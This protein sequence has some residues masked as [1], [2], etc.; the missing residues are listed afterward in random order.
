MSIL[1]DEEVI[2]NCITQIEE[3]HKE[4]GDN[5][6]PYQLFSERFN[7]SENVI[8]A[9]IGYCQQHGIVCERALHINSNGREIALIKV[10]SK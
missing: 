6:I 5:F 1:T 4:Y 3:T 7:S 9:V 10:L 2:D 8:N